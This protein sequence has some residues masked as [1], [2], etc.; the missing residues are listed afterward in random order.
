MRKYL[1]A[2]MAAA[3]VLVIGGVAMAANVYTVDGEA[4]PRG[5][6][7]KAKPRP[8]ALRFEYTVTDSDPNLRATPVEGYFIAS[9]GLITFP[10]AFPTCTYTQANQSD[11]AAA[12]RACRRAR[13]GGGGGPNGLGVRND[14]G[15]S[16]DR[17]AKLPCNL[18]LNLYNLAPGQFPD[19]ANPGQTIT[20][21]RRH[22]GLA[23]R[24]DGDQAIPANDDQIACPTPQHTAIPAR[25]VPVRIDGQPADELR[26]EVPPNLLHPSGLD[27]SVRETLSRVL[28]RTAVKR[29]R[30]KR[31][32]VGYY[33]SVGCRGRRLL[34]V[35][36]VAED[37]ARARQTSDEPCG[38]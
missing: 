17:S 16:S 33:S 22:G 6:G 3:A 28:R 36:F 21:T 25:F 27:T 31:R 20:I 34:R 5:K 1:I 35:T 38:G 30:G 23:I 29:I 14:V 19:P 12:E 32:R 4:T 9:E 13:V 24:L 37:G 8:V 18:E 26:F 11:Q 10:E 7:S 2:A 15:A